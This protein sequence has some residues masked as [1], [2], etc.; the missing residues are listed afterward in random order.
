MSEESQVKELNAEPD[1][2]IDSEDPIALRQK[3][4][5]RNRIIGASVLVVLVV[6]VAALQLLGNDA[7]SRQSG[8]EIDEKV[9][10]SAVESGAIDKTLNAFGTLASAEEEDV[11]VPGE[12]RVTRYHVSVGDAVK[13]GDKIATVDRSTVLAA[14]DDIQS[15]IGEVDDEVE[16]LKDSSASSSITASAEGT[17]V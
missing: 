17:V 6:A 11:S 8:A 7:A 16:N 14:I 9:I 15:L 3:K 10:E 13:K 12:I 2:A 4:R 5:R 1:V